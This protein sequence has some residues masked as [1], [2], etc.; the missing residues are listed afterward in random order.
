MMMTGDNCGRTAEAVPLPHAQ[1]HHADCTDSRYPAA[2]SEERGPVLLDLEDV[3][4]RLRAM[5]VRCRQGEDGLWAGKLCLHAHGEVSVDGRVRGLDPAHLGQGVEG[6]IE[7]LR[8]VGMILREPKQSVSGNGGRKRGGPWR[9]LHHRPPPRLKGKRAAVAVDRMCAFLD[10][11]QLSY[12]QLG[13]GRFL[14]CRRVYYNPPSGRIRLKGH[15]TH[16]VKGFAALVRILAEEANNPKLG[17]LYSQ[18]L[19]QDDL[20]VLVTDDPLERTWAGSM[21]ARALAMAARSRPA[22]GA[23]AQKG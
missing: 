21:A 11:H 23:V 9:L 2:G 20:G 13:P 15:H 18:S 16:A 7:A 1:S 3:A 12:E 22:R 4:T 17:H 14:V 19:R 8:R 5:G 6:F 10:E